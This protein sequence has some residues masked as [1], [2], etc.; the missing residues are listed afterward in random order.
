MEAHA[1][2]SA[3]QLNQLSNASYIKTETDQAEDP[4]P[5]N[6]LVAVRYQIEGSVKPKNEKKHER[7]RF[8]TYPWKEPMGHSAGLTHPIHVLQRKRG[9]FGGETY[10]IELLNQSIGTRLE[11]TIRQKFRTNLGHWGPS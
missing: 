1:Y 6:V 5:P 11:S 4:Y 10:V 9:I 3:M 2:Q 7:A 8:M